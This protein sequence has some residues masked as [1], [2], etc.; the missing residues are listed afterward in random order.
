MIVTTGLVAKNTCFSHCQ[1]SIQANPKPPNHKAS[2]STT[3]R[4]A[5]REW[6]ENTE[7]AP[8][9]ARL[10]PCCFSWT[11]VPGTFGA[12]PK[13]EALGAARSG[14]A[15]PA[16]GRG[17][18]RDA[19]WLRSRCRAPGLAQHPQLLTGRGRGL[20]AEKHSAVQA[21]R[22]PGEERAATLRGCRT[23]HGSAR[24]AGRAPAS[25]SARLR[26]AIT[27]ATRLRH[28]PPPF[29]PLS[30]S[31][32]LP[33]PARR[34]A[35]MLTSRTFL[36]RTRAGSVLKVVREHYLRDDIPCGAAA[37]P[38]CPPRPD[39]GPSALE[40]RPGGAASSL[41]PGP[42]YLLPDTNLLLHQVSRHRAR[43]DASPRPP[44]PRGP[45]PG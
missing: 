20:A 19:P 40:E 41:C 9:E 36:K 3:Q 13:T 22:G 37:C 24:P 38:L 42:H 16:Q 17:Q 29:L 7:E 4:G 26:D 12:P 44:S 2:E 35:A 6:A 32:P 34:P 11:D 33:F 14:G 39:G 1:K 28:L 25:P 31:L 30:F 5:Q 23:P 43:H 15:T 27:A 18:H 10:R 21:S 8:P 45:S